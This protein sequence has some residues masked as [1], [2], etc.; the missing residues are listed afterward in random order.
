MGGDDGLT[1]LLP[2][3]VCV[4]ALLGAGKCLGAVLGVW[5]AGL[6]RGVAM[7]GKVAGDAFSSG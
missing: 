3:S 6:G 1:P 2:L 7:C 5:R 4:F